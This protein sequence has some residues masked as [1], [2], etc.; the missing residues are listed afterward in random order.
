MGK[1]EF[2]PAA[3]SVWWKF[4]ESGATTAAD[5]SGY[6]NAGT[7]TNMAGNESTAGKPAA[8]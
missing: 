2:T 1:L 7:L 4:D 8:G 6:G 3:E 5:S